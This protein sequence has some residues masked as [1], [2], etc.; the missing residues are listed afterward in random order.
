[1]VLGV[2]A[3]APAAVI[4]YTTPPGST[5]GG[6]PVDVSAT[7]TTSAGQ[8]QI[9][10]NNL[11]ADPVSVIQNLSDLDF[12][13]S[14]GQTTGATLASSSG[15]SRTVGKAASGDDNPFTDNGTIATGWGLRQSF[16]VPFGLGTGFHLCIICSSNG[17]E[18]VGPTGNPAHTIIGPAAASGFYES[19]QGSIAG[20]VAHNPFLFGPV[21]FTLNISGLT[22]ASTI[23]GVV[24]SFGTTT[25][26][27]TQGCVEGRCTSVPL[28]SSMLMVGLGTV[29]AAG[30]FVRSRRRDAR[31]GVRLVA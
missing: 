19:A 23:T 24:F 13:V 31:R 1:M 28:P 16:P 15:T 14:S 4:T 22:D 18:V 29:M 30:A 3:P 8:L 5:Q 10:V 26:N 11:Q 12:V 27:D 9:V 17:T 25:G 2:T 6:H 21:T 7:F 20:S